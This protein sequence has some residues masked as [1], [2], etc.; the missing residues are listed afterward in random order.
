MPI[1]LNKQLNFPK[2]LMI[3]ILNYIII[4]S[5]FQ[6]E[7]SKPVKHP[8]NSALCGRNALYIAISA[9]CAAPVFAQK[10]ESATIEE[11]IVFGQKIERSLQDTP[12]SIA[13]IDSLSL[14]QKELGNLAEAVLEAPNVHAY[15]NGFNIRGIDTNNVSGAGNGGLATVYL[16][17]SPLN[18]RLTTNGVSTWDISQVE[19]L[20]GPQSTLQGRNALAGSIIMTST[21]PS[22]EWEAKYRLEIGE[23]GQQEAAVAFGGGL[24]EDELAFRISL[25]DQSFDGFNRNIVRNEYSDS[26]DDKLYRAKFL[27]T[28]SA[29]PDFSAQLNVTH[30]ETNRGTDLVNT[31]TNGENPYDHRIVTNND[32][33]R[34]NYEGDIIAL[35]LG[36]DINDELSLSIIS[37]HS[38]IESSWDDYDDDNGPIAG[39]TRYYSETNKTKSHEVRLNF[40]YENFKGVLGAYYFDSEVP[41]NWGGISRISLASVGLSAPILQSRFGLDSNTANF[42]VAQYAPLDPAQLR[43]LN[44]SYT[45]TQSKALFADAT[46]TINEQWDIFAGIRWDKEE[47]ESED[48]TNLEIANAEFFPDPSVYP[49]PLNQLI[50]GINA[51]LRNTAAQASTDSPLTGDSFSEV[52]PKIGAS[53]RINED[54]TASLTLQKGYRSGGVGVNTVRG[55]SYQYDPETTDNIELSLRSVWL[56]GD[57]IVNANAFYLDW[58]DQQVSVQRSTNTFDT[59]IVNAGS[60]EVKGFE[61]ETTYTPNTQWQFTAGV[62]LA[63]TEFKEFNVVIPTEGETI[64]RD[65]SGRNFANAPEWTANAGVR[66]T[67]DNGIFANLNVNYADSTADVVDPFASGLNPGDDG[68]DPQ[69]DARTL[70]NMRIGYEWEKVGVYLVAKNLLDK[71]Y[72]EGA[73]FGQ[74]RRVVRHEL[75]DPRQLSLVVRG[76]F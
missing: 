18:D 25:E 27:Y 71:E 44:S 45:Q 65:L 4:P 72:L 34:L 5:I 66:Y 74:G 10:I 32:P 38:E 31:P 68:F 7:S 6:L 29:L 70:V 75:G 50:A 17:N 47:Y 69:N 19:V 22:Q 57:L 42:V 76:H 21:K 49:A 43:Q 1:T 63:K 41:A 11:V 24:I 56:D 59:E 23:E 20:R 48:S 39:G 54:V 73:A 53:Y 61:L 8:K 16:D 13:V 52:L 46:Y 30:T 58:K 28:P 64:V 3:I 37:T 51:Q 9:V 14:D 33:Q 2:K 36:Y 26:R 12:A 35:D 15:A 55:S 60:S 67:A 62:G 40:N